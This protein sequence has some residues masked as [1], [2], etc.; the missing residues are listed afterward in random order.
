M[1]PSAIHIFYRCILGIATNGNGLPQ[2]LDIPVSGI[3][4]GNAIEYGV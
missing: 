4:I 3:T 2:G 1:S